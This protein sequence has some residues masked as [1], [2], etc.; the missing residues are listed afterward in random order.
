MFEI[1]Y[2]WNVWHDLSPEPLRYGEPIWTDIRSILYPAHRAETKT[3]MLSKE[4]IDRTIAMKKAAQ[5]EKWII[6]RTCIQ[7]LVILF[8]VHDW[9]L[10]STILDGSCPFA[11][12]DD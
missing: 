2:P 3:K 4:L 6:Y 7:N 11:G 9:N 12:K 5:G 1:G 10:I 8:F